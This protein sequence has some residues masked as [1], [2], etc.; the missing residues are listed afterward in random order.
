LTAP[1]FFLLLQPT[2]V[3][4]PHRRRQT[5]KDISAVNRIAPGAFL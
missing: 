3:L 1:S 5:E 4:L 2:L